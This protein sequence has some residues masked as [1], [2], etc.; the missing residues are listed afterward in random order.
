MLKPNKNFTSGCSHSSCIIFILTSHSLPA[1]VMLIVILIEVQYLQ[2][3]VFSF[4]KGSNGQE[5]FSSG[6]HYQ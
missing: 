3:V 6:S 5:H 1:Q 2:N 4:K